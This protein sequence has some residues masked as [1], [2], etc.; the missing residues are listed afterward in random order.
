[1]PIGIGRWKIIEQKLL[2][3][4]ENGVFV[5]GERLPTEMELS[6]RFGVGRHSMRRAIKALA[7]TGALRIRQGA[8]T[9][10]ADQAMLSYAIGA[11]TRFRHN[12]SSQ[13]L[14]ASSDLLEAAVVPASP[15]VAAAL[16]LKPDDPVFQTHAV[17]KAD[18]VPISLSRA[19]FPAERF[20]DLGVRRAKGHSIS[21]VYADYGIGDYRR[22]ETTM[23]ARPARSD[24]AAR[25]DMSEGHPVVIITKTDV[26]LDGHPIGH[27]KV[28]WAAG[29]VQFTFESDFQADPSEGEN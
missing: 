29:R 22:L 20:P 16:C 28:V 25:L 21:A 18:G 7:D 9:F 3:D 26:D 17:G 15:R 11:R 19:W 8:G 4:I 23:H 2:A 6:D 5:P 24:E 27:G 10:V 13:G 12:L 1:M 14:A